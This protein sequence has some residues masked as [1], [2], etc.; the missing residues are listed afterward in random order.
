MKNQITIQMIEE[1]ISEINKVVKLLNPEFVYFKDTQQVLRSD[2]TEAA[3]F[4]NIDYYYVLFIER[5]DVFSKF[6]EEK[7]LLYKLDYQNVISYLEII[8]DL[9]TYKSHRIDMNLQRERNIVN[10]VKKWYF[11]YVGTQNPSIEEKILCIPI[12]NKMAYLILLNVHKC[13]E[14]I[15]KDSRRDSIIDEMKVVQ[16]KYL[17]DYVIIE[18]AEKVI[19]N[20]QIQV[21]SYKFVKRFGSQIKKKMEL[22]VNDSKETKIK[23]LKLCIE[24]VLVKNKIG[25]CPL[26]YNRIKEV[27]QN[28]TEKELVDLKK[29]AAQISDDNMFL[30]AENIL[31]ILLKE[32]PLNKEETD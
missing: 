2:K 22:Y 5:D 19:K 16:E 7:I 27:Y 3:Y 31:Q 24:D 15:N 29:R 14:R 12:L 13:L 26:S 20:M 32:I 9:R 4:N 25:L 8:H 6:I 21:D 17:P 28:R 23:I 1:E 10:R 11:E 30:T 18:E